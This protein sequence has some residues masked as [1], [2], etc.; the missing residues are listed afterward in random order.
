MPPERS[1]VLVGGVGAKG[2]YIFV[3]ARILRRVAACRRSWDDRK[4]F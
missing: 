2:T 4:L 1:V 3:E